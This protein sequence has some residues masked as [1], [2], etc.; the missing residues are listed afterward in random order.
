MED[1]RSRGYSA[2]IGAQPK[3]TTLKRQFSQFLGSIMLQESHS[4]LLEK[5]AG[6]VEITQAR[7]K[8]EPFCTDGYR[9]AI[10]GRP[11]PAVPSDE[12]TQ[13]SSSKLS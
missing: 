12:A 1:M 3:G 4:L 13:G 2:P 10:A 11:A 9:Q 5:K 6:D 8:I 7:P